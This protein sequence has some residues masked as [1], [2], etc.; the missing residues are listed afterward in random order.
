MQVDSKSWSSKL[1][2]LL[3]QYWPALVAAA[4]ACLAIYWLLPRARRYPPLWGAV[5]AALALIAF[6]WLLHHTE[7]VPLEALLF[8]IFA[9]LAVIFGGLMITQ[10]NPVHAALSFAMVVLSTCGLFLLLA[11]PFLMAAT[12]IIYAGAIVVTFLFVIMLAQQEGISSAD[13]RSR[14]PFLATVAGF[15]LLAALL[16]VLQRTYSSGL[17]PFLDKAEQAAAA[18]TVTEVQQILGNDDAYFIDF[19]N[20]VLPQGRD[21]SHGNPQLPAAVAR[22]KL[23]SRLDAAQ[24]AWNRIK[25]NPERVGE[26][27]DAGALFADF[28]NKITEVRDLT[29]EVRYSQGSLR[30]S[31]DRPLS[32]FSGAPGNAPLAVD[33]EGKISER[34]R[35][36]NV[37]GLGKT[38]FSDYLLAVELAGTLLLIATI[39]AIAM[40]GRRAEVLR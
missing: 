20:Q 3:T 9:A 18:T 4:L 10:R 38:L 40:A 22:A 1:G 36:A 8:Y 2:V 11:A 21:P 12:I 32:K 28:H 5:A 29:V 7:L 39:G 27:K 35:A 24:D 23:Y 17:E 14:E 15:V 31:A 26:P 30:P 6:G 33:K 16:C 25:P 19:R 37:E 13:Q 34:L